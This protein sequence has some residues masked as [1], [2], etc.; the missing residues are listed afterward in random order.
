MSWQDDDM[1]AAGS[2]DEGDGGS[3]DTVK[4][5]IGELGLKDVRVVGGGAE[6]TPES[7]ED[8][9]VHLGGRPGFRVQGFTL[10][11]AARHGTA[12]CADATSD[13]NYPVTHALSV[14]LPIASVSGE[15]LDS[16]DFVLCPANCSTALMRVA[17]IT[18]RH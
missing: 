5:E 13:T 15:L 18:L 8:V 1:E 12:R 7:W 3:W 4:F 10:K 11:G 9:Q 17:L 6:Q 16:F 14:G 2:G